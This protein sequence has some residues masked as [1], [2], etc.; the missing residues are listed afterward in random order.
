MVS[1]DLY[2]KD[3]VNSLLNTKQN[4]LVSGT[5]I[6]TVNGTSLLGAGDIS[7]SAG[8]LT[9]CYLNVTP[10]YDIT[11]DKIYNAIRNTLGSDDGVFLVELISPS[12]SIISN[13]SMFG[14]WGILDTGGACIVNVMGVADDFAPTKDT[15]V[16][17]GGRVGGR[18]GGT[19]PGTVNKIIAYNTSNNTTSVVQMPAT[20]NVFACYLGKGRTN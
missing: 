12:T 7:I 4:Q 2:S 1:I 19:N 9:K 15:Y 11:V 8:T 13:E 14:V 10:D 17:L 3:Q 6:R 20:F 18:T 16:I 5:N